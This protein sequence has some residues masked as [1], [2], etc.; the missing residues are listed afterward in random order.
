MTS[1]SPMIEP[2]VIRGL[3]DAYG[4]W[5]MICISLRSARSD[6]LSSVVTFRPWNVTSPDVGSI[7]RRIVRPVVDFPQP[8]SPTSPSV[9][10]A[11]MSNETSSTA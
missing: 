10:P 7:S 4:S 8:D 5:K 6:R 11:M 1:A 9:S 2:T 3:S